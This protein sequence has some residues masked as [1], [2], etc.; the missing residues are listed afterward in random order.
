M[1]TVWLAWGTTDEM[2]TLKTVLPTDRAMF[3]KLVAAALLGS[4]ATNFWARFIIP[5]KPGVLSSPPASLARE[6]RKA[7]SQAKSTN[8]PS[9]PAS[10]AYHLADGSASGGGHFGVEGRIGAAGL[11]SVCTAAAVVTSARIIV[12]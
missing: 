4:T 9:G 1:G 12:S 10:E 3:Q 2:H 5:S 11:R 7:L 8:L 6:L